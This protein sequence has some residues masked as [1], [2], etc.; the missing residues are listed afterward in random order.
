MSF[1]CQCVVS[2]AES[3]PTAWH[4]VGYTSPI[5]LDCQ[6]CVGSRIS[7]RSVCMCQLQLFDAEL[8]SR[9][10]LQHLAPI[11]RVIETDSPG[12]DHLY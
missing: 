6:P 11:Y 2:V 9:L 4:C 8:K 3:S 10:C 12:S 7:L 1:V 5:V